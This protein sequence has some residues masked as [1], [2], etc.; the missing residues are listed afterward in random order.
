MRT[1]RTAFSLVEVLVALALIVVTLSLF[2]NSFGKARESALL[3]DDRMKAVHFS[4]KN[5]ET[6]ITN[7]YASRA[8]SITNCRNWVTNTSVSGGVTSSFFCSYSVVTGQFAKSRTI[9]LT[10]FWFDPVSN[11]T[12]FSAL[13]TSVCSGFQY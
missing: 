11:K 4:R 8:L 1:S 5:L 2:V 10:N 12:N 9:L 7:T 6:L 13:S 3:A